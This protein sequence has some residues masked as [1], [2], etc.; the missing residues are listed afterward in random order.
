MVVL[1][2]VH[3][4]TAFELAMKIKEP[5]ATAEAHATRL[6]QGS[7]RGST[8]GSPRWWGSWAGMR[9]IRCALARDR[10]AAPS[11]TYR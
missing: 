7:W 2:A 5:G 4:A 8:P 1:G 11:L 10:A 3:F 9:D 6:F